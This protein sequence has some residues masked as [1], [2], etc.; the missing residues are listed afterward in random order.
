MTT[1][2]DNKKV[3]S[4]AIV[5]A[6]GSSSRMGQSKQLLKI[7]G[8]SLLHRTI[9]TVIDSG[10]DKVIVVLGSN[11][12]T[13]QKE[14]ADLPIQI[15]SNSNWEKGIGSSIKSGV[16]FVNDHFPLS[17][18][19]LF[20][21]CDQPL[22][23][24]DHLKKMIHTFQAKKSI[25]ASFYS[26]SPGVPALFDRSMFEKLLQV[27]DGQGAKKILQDN[28]EAVHVIDFPQG[29]IDLDTPGDW[30]KFLQ[31]KR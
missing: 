30:E 4:V 16:E 3:K 10:V 7:G 6:A 23:D 28:I 20:T 17:H 2:Q 1:E 5:L 31:S 25:V 11:Q 19:I 18:S 15:I 27:N 22:L 8:E 13:H 14:I 29:E 26:G 24:S 9:K 12:Q 21:V